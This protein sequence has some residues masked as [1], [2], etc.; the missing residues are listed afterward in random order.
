MGFNL[1]IVNTSYKVKNNGKRKLCFKNITCG[2]QR[3]SQG[4]IFQ[5]GS[6][7]GVGRGKD[8]EDEVKS[9]F[10]L[11]KKTKNFVGEVRGKNIQ[12]SFSGQ[13]V[14]LIKNQ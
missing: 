6:E 3:L 5:M 4:E 1:L 2:P 13:F 11:W 10:V 12:A 9:E 14:G 8:I 7:E